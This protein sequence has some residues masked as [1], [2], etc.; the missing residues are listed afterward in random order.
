MA[1]I[2][3]VVSEPK[4]EIYN[5]V[6]VALIAIPNGAT[7]CAAFA[8]IVGAAPDPLATLKTPAVP[9]AASAVKYVFAPVESGVASNGDENVVADVCAAVAIVFT[10]PLPSAPPSE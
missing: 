2:S 7:N 10:E 5:C 3:A 1:P 4:S 8:I 6:S 9:S